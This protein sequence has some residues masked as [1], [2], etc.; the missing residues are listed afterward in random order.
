[1]SPGKNYRSTEYL[2]IFSIACWFHKIDYISI[3]TAHFPRFGEILRER[4]TRQHV[5]V[6]FHSDFKV[7]IKEKSAKMGLYLFVFVAILRWP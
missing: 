4:I 6:G 5:F 1:M 7:V 3:P 2:V